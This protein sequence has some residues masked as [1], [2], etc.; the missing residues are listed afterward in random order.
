MSRIRSPLNARAIVIVLLLCAPVI[1]Y[2]IL[3]VHALWKT[4]VASWVWW[5]LP[6]CWCLTWVVARLWPPP[7]AE[8]EAL[9]PEKH[10]TDR[11]HEATAIVRRYQQKVN[12]LTPSQMTDPHFAIEEMKSLAADLSQHYHPGATQP[13]DLLTVPEVLAAMRLAIDDMERWTLDSVP[14]SRLL[15]IRQWQAF[16]HA[17]RWAKRLQDMSWAAWILMNPAN[18]ALYFSSK[19]TSQP[20]VTSLGNEILALLYTQFVRQIGFYL[21]EM[22]SGRLRGGADA[23]RTSMRTDTDPIARHTT[24]NQVDLS[25]IEAVPV[26]IAIVGQ[27]SAGKSSL[28]N[29]LLGEHS[30]QVDLLPKTKHVGRYHFQSDDGIDITLLDT[31]GYGDSGATRKQ[32]KQIRE[33]LTASDA[34]LLVMDG[35]SPARGADCQTLQEL[36]GWYAT[37][38]RLK[39]PAIIGILTHIDLLP[40]PLEWDPPYDWRNPE[41]EKEV[42]IAEAV[43]YTYEVFGDSIV[44]D[45]VPACLSADASRQWGV[46]EEIVPSLLAVLD[47]VKCVAILRKFESELD[48]GKL[49]TVLQQSK[50]AGLSLVRAWIDAE[51]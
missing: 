32:I 10:W 33:A 23:Y 12:E 9:Q 44:S 28:I 36:Q 3:G 24:H 27:V 31:P 38:P 18:L 48:I 26:T 41:S 39:S 15:T 7:S 49:R 20:V 13:L 22:N 29:A 8:T 34:V 1:G 43:N 25:S 21:I 30:A 46:A 14:G 17:P 4:G 16:R 51:R 42:Q 50:F 45:V 6:V 5:A 35:H 37:Q 11:D 47:D 2:A 40:P 19:H